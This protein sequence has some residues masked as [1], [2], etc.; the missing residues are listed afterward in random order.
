VYKSVAAAMCWLCSDRFGTV[1]CAGFRLSVMSETARRVAL[2]YKQN[3]HI[4]TTTKNLICYSSNSQCITCLSDDIQGLTAR[5]MAIHYGLRSRVHSKLVRLSSIL[6]SPCGSK[7][8]V[9]F[10]CVKQRLLQSDTNDTLPVQRFMHNKIALLP[11][12]PS[13]IPGSEENEAA[14]STSPCRLC[15]IKTRN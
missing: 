15:L 2:I 8:Q 5:Q 6:P 14:C 13:S 1:E 12:Q 10:F 7:H 11:K 9:S 4:H 3:R